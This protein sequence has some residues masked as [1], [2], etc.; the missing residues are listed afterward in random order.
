[1]IITKRRKKEK[2]NSKLTFLRYNKK[3]SLQKG[4]FY[5]K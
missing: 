2:K 5:E 3:K 4:W 1:M